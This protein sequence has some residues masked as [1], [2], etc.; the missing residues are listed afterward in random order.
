MKFP[1]VTHTCFHASFA[2]WGCHHCNNKAPPHYTA[3]K[4]PLFT[5]C[6]T[7]MV[8]SSVHTQSPAE[9][10]APGREQAPVLYPVSGSKHSITCLLPKEW[11][12]RLTKALWPL[13]W[14]E[15]L[16]L[17]WVSIWTMICHIKAH[18]SYLRRCS[19]PFF[20]T[21]L[22]SWWLITLCAAWLAWSTCWQLNWGCCWGLFCA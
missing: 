19:Q 18:F 15:K 1:I 5:W 14:T 6:H 4:K 7:E 12:S 13:T 9:H 21:S 8:W 3:V 16:C 17:T 20:N 10:G 2:N 11:S 22:V